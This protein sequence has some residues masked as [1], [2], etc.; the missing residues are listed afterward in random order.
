MVCYFQGF[1][2]ICLDIYGDQDKIY[3]VICKLVVYNEGDP[4]SGEGGVGLQLGIIFVSVLG[5]KT[6]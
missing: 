4:V 5:A 3:S 1:N 2:I 6:N